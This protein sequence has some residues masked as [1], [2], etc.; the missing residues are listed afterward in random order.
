ME[1]K[2]E[3][4]QALGKKQLKLRNNYCI[5]KSKNGLEISLLVIKK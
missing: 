4:E 1:V 2:F 5:L 3:N